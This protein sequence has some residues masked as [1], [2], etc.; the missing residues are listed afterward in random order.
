MRPNFDL[1]RAV[2]NSGRVVSFSRAVSIS[3]STVSISS[4]S[5]NDKSGAKR[6]VKAE[7]CPRPRTK[8][9]VMLREAISEKKHQRF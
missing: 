5:E 6:S 4:R 3:G 1:G 7:S 2:L 9:K 8:A